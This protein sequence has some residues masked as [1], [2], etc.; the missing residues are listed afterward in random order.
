MV[1]PLVDELVYVDTGSL[2][3]SREI[4]V[5]AGA[6]VFDYVW[7]D[8]FAAARNFSLRQASSDYIMI[9][10]PDEFVSPNDIV[11]LKEMLDTSAASA[12]LFTTRN[13]CSEPKTAGYQRLSAR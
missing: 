10:D 3:D 7:D 12:Y 8:D 2:D 4:S 6:R 11:R 5:Q 1:K 9:L 13:Y